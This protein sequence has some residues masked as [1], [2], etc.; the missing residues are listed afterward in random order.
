M[1][2]KSFLSAGEIIRKILSQDEAVKA[3]G[4]TKVYPLVVSEAVLPYVVYYRT[5]MSRTA[6]KG[7]AGADT[8]AMDVMCFAAD[9]TA[10]VE[11]AEA[12]RE[13]LDGV[14]YADDDG[15]VMR[16]CQLVDSS[17]SYNGEAYVQTLSFEIKI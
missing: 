1:M 7:L 10:S 6:V 2:K 16:S 14:N 3:L 13:A 15:Y 8:V 4:T 12:V 9:Y 17:E 11:L 5:G